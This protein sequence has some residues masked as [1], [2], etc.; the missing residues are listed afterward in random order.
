M[1]TIT[2]VED[3]HLWMAK[4]FNDHPLFD[5]IA[6]EELEGDVCVEIM[7]TDTEEGKKVTRNKGSKFIACFRRAE[8]PEW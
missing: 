2:D 6:E 4:H 7:K 8:D 1:Y 3:L 5:R